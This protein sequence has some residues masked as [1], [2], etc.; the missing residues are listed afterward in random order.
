MNEY[1]T[2]ITIDKKFKNEEE[3]FMITMDNLRTNNP[4]C[5]SESR[6]ETSIY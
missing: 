5:L 1:I 3:C 6:L 2:N 4:R